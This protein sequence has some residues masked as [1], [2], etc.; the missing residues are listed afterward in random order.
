MNQRLCNGI[1]RRDC[2]QAGVLGLTGLTL[3]DWLAAADSDKDTGSARNATADSVLF[4]N[5]AGGPSH[6]DTLDMKPDLPKES[7]SEF[8]TIQSRIE[9]LAVC[10]H[11][12]KLAQMI[13]RFTLIRG[14]SHS[15]GAHPEGQ[16]YIS[17]GNRPSPAVICPSYGSVV[18]KELP[19]DADLP[20][21]V[22]IPKSEWK[23]GYMGDAF[24]PFQTQ[25]VPRPG[26]P[27]AVRGISLPEGISIEKVNR[28]DKLLS[29]L[30]QR[31]KELDS[32]NQLLEALD[33]FGRQAHSMM[34]SERTRVAFDVGREPE[35]IQKLFATDETNQGLL[36]AVRLIEAGVR[37]VTVS[38]FGWD[39]HLDNFSG[40]ARLIPPLDSGITATINALEEKGLLERT[41]V[42]VMGEFGR[43]PKINQNNGRDHY[44]AVNWC[45]M[46][47]AGVGKA[48]LIGSTDKGGVAPSDGTKISPDDIGASIFHAL[49]IDHHKE[50][51]TKTGR[52]IELIPNGNVIDGLFV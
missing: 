10:E 17:T 35:S 33:T 43:T 12:P 14:I 24:A 41:L 19:G 32:D 49:G 39:T 31:F 1:T 37:F 42:V 21:Y 18:S 20:P 25:A 30:N 45:L 51:Y 47:G 36:L 28:R 22:A 8:S 27:F 23:A 50:F 26:K 52:P 48:Q 5:L 15:S 13:D 44:P 4:V 3:P 9:G 38:N 16:S 40:H 11:F 46:A 6:L 29:E 34:T 2:V 7:V